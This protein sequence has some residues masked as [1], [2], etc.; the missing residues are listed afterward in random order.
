[1]TVFTLAQKKLLTSDTDRNL[2]H[3]CKHK[4]LHYNQ[5]SDYFCIRSGPFLNAD[6]N[7]IHIQSLSLS[8]INLN[9]WVR[10]ECKQI[11]DTS[12]V[13]GECKQ[14]GQKS[15]MVKRSDLCIKTCSVNA[16]YF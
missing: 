12:H 2:L 6:F 13:W 10:N 4:N 16:A 14:A 1:M 3:T 8:L 9:F 15:D 11:S 5:K 7:W